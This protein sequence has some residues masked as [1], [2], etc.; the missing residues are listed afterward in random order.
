MTGIINDRVTMAHA[1]MGQIGGPRD[2]H[3][4]DKSR[5]TA[6]FRRGTRVN[7]ADNHSFRSFPGAQ[8]PRFLLGNDIA[9]LSDARIYFYSYSFCMY[10]LLYVSVCISRTT[11]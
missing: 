9:T 8:V 3:G 10:F 11:L 5:A 4:A 1:F 2:L 7:E 6:Y